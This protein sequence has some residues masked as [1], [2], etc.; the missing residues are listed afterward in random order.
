MTLGQLIA[1]GTPPT[2]ARLMLA[3]LQ[4]A[5]SRFDIDSPARLGCFIAQCL[6]ESTHFTD[7][8]ENLW[9]TTPE[10]I[11][12]YFPS[13]VTSLQQASLLV[14]NPKALANCIYAGKNGNGNPLSGDGW[15][16]R[17]RGGIELSGKGN[18]SDAATE[19]G[20]PYLEQPDLVAA[21][22]DAALTAAWFWHTRKCNFLADAMHVDAITR[23]VNGPA[24]DQHALRLQL[25]EQAVMAFSSAA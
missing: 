5:C 3:P 13:H 25:S 2:Q 15:N 17:G 18:Y 9:W 4:A 14:R 22:A 16:Y 10:R 8:E 12:K 23:A 11:L 19:L 24:M 1:A 6:V 7:F 21:P 20:R